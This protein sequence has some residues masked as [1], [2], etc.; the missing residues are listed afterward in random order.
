[1]HNE[2]EG[3]TCGV[4][5]LAVGKRKT[6]NTNSE[7]GTS[8]VDGGKR[9]DIPS[10]GNLYGVLISDKGKMPLK[11]KKKEGKCLTNY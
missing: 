3:T 7:G 1:M 6:R 2:N 9:A 10:R 8:L 4:N 5:F 11:G